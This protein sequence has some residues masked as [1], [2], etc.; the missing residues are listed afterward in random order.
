MKEVK[1]AIVY[2]NIDPNYAKLNNLP[3]KLPILV[4][5]FQNA[6]KTNKIP[7]DVIIRGLE[8]Q[9]DIDKNNRY[10]ISYLVYYYYEAFKKHLNNTDFEK[11]KEF[12]DKA[13]KIYPDYRLHFYTGLYYKKLGNLELAELHLKQSLKEKPN[14]AYGYYELG[15]LMYERNIYDEALEYYSKSVELEKDFTLGFLKMA[16]VYMENGR[17][18]EAVSLLQKCIEIDNKFVP[19]YERLGVALN[20]LQR[21]K[22]AH[23]VH[24][25]ALEI[26]SDRYE[27]YYNDAHSLARLGNHNEAIKALEKAVSLNETDYILH[28]L[29]L[30]YKNMGR[31]LQAIE[32]EEKALEI[33]SE[34]NKNFI[35]LT[36]LK[37]YVIIENEEQVEKYFEI[38]N[39][40][41]D[42]HETAVNFKVLFELSQGRIEKVKEILLKEPLS[43]FTLILDKLDRLDIYVSK[44]E[45]CA[46]KKISESIFESIDEFGNIDPF[47]L[48]EH[49]TAKEI[50][51]PF[52]S[53][54]KESSIEP[55]LYPDGVEFLT[56]GLLLSGF[57]YGLSERVATAISQYLWKDGDGLAFG[58]LLLRFYQDRILGESLPLESFIQENVEE[59]KDMSFTFAQIFANYEEHL[60]DF[61]SIVEF[62]INNFKDAL[63]VFL[64]MFRIITTTVEVTSVKFND[65]NTQN[66]SLFIHNINSISNSFSY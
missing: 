20:M 37:L 60:M 15:N 18:E 52:V 25:K 21:Y 12:L 39:L 3:V 10:Y 45:D 7:L 27:I 64:S 13:G 22:D 61:D 34:Q 50:K 44:L 11:A 30:E 28:E 48:S 43:N 9:V 54:L 46:D 56:N 38:L 53:W 35:I 16:D 14:F 47:S 57:N 42:F 41:P 36:L 51:R 6:R 55:K 62:K 5:D 23:K 4:E 2:L 17:F 33:A 24:Q 26:D 8:A 65:Y 58:R 32:T 29:A 66:L 40:N 1:Y 63:K 19:A 59:I 31:Y 49:L